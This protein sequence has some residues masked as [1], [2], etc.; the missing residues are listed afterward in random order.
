MGEPGGWGSPEWR[1]STVRPDAESL[2]GLAHPLRLRL[3]GLLRLEGPSTASKLAGQVGESSGSTSYHL[4][5][6][7]KHGFV[8]ETEGPGSRRERW[9][10][11][12]HRQ[13]S[14]PVGPSDAGPAGEPGALSADDIAAAGEIL[15]HAQVD[16]EARAVGRWIGDR[17]S[18]SP[19]WQDAAGSSDYLVHLTPA[20]TRAL[21]DEL[22]AVV[23]R[24]RAAAE[25]E[26][27][28]VTTDIAHPD[29]DVEVT[30]EFEHRG[31]DG[32]HTAGDERTAAD[33][34][35]VRP[36]MLFVRAVPY[37]AQRGE[38]S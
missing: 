31:R 12:A 27:A 16:A 13:T 18:W 19:A 8:E 23:E 4:R 5:Q 25:D 14:W 3:L 37:V 1:A 2:R 28:R 32:E 38:R 33:E 24:H 26:V 21:F 11:A 20:R 36:V 9:W 22:E 29:D 30:A 6:L 7:A 10:R 35:D 34:Q 17:R 15:L